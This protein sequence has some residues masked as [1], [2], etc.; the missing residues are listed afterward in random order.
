MNNPMNLSSIFNVRP[1]LVSL[2]FV[3]VLS[4][5]IQSVAPRISIAADTSRAPILNGNPKSSGPQQKT[6]KQKADKKKS[7]QQDNRKK[8]KKKT[9]PF[10][11]VNKPTQFLAKKLPY[12]KHA[13]FQSPSMK[14]SV[15]FCIYLPPHYND[16]KQGDRR[17]PVVYYLH[18]GRPGSELKSIRLAEQIHQHISDGSIAPMIYV[19]VNG[20]PV[21]HYDLPGKANSEGASVFI[22]ELI[23]HVD[24][25]Y[26]TIANRKGR[27]LEGFSQ[28]GRGTARLMFRHPNLFC[29]ASPGGGGHATEKKIS[30]NGGA[31]SE[32]L[33]FAEGDNTWDLAKAYAAGLKKSGKQQDL[34]I[35][36][37]VG[38]K[39][40]NYQNNLSWMAHLKELGIEHRKI[41]V[42][43][44]GH[45]AK[46]IYQKSGK[47]IMEFHTRN[48]ANK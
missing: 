24:K 23:P 12:V 34:K 40:F 10:K 17:F 31:E 8:S 27:G 37:H 35:L 22:N 25:T 45:S 18:G 33:K 4:V 16:T 20:G 42:P 1:G 48:F 44:A 28:G 14:T 32:R 38:D 6:S 7:F 39:G 41:I 5:A 47:E 13:T 29:S 26:R 11:W 3:F 21:S 9:L 19:F 30:E 36:V 2:C 43:G 46:Q 15:G